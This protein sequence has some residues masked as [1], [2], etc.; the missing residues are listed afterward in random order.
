MHFLSAA[1]GGVDMGARE[2]HHSPNVELAAIRAMTGLFAERSD[3][4]QEHLYVRLL[5][6]LAIQSQLPGFINSDEPEP[7]FGL[8]CEETSRPKNDMLEYSVAG[9]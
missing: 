6:S 4:A 1:I 3:S 9:I 7:V 2:N 5:H 8:D